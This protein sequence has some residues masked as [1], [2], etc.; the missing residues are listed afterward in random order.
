MIKVSVGIIFI[1]IVG[2]IGLQ[3]DDEL[4]PDA[5]R[6]IQ[7]SNSQKDSE[8]Y[9]FLMG[10]YSAKDVSPVDVGE[11]IYS[12]IRDGEEKY[13]LEKVPFDYTDY[14]NEDKIELP[15]GKLFCRSWEKGC[16]KAIFE[17]ATEARRTLE[18]HSIL[19][20]RYYEFINLHGY[21]AM[22][23]PMIT[24][25]LPPF[26]YLSVAHRLS[27][28]NEIIRSHDGRPV[29]SI[30][31]LYLNF[32]KLRGVL[33]QQDTIVGKM[34]VL[35]M[36]SETLDIISILA[37]KYKVSSIEKIAHITKDERDLERSMAREVGMAYDTFRYLD[38]NPELWKIGGGAFG[39]VARM[40]FKPNMTLNAAYPDYKRISVASQLSQIEF[41]NFIKNGAENISA[42][43]SLRNYAGVK[44]NNI[45]RPS[46]IEYVA[47]FFDINC[48]I[49]QINSLVTNAGGT[50][51]FIDAINPYGKPYSSVVNNKGGRVCYDGPLKDGHN[52]RCLAIEI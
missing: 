21:K 20:N 3:F 19:L 41:S 36:L 29:E 52:L 4:H 50:D 23:K 44:L 17:D 12:S 37:G 11:S 46:M 43:E 26:N 6:W 25:P 32:A 14:P 10:I 28:L 49:E 7:E 35:M 38:R 42:D 24:E 2:V 39:W 51:K 16:L 31:N 48:K 1:I 15:Q 5:A 9:F 18:S 30:R 47:R 33:Q 40:A 27:S 22:T 13:I 8:A 45:A 34:V